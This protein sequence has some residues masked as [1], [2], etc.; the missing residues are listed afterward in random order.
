MTNLRSILGFI[1]ILT[2]LAMPHY[3]V[4]GKHQRNYNVGIEIISD[5]RGHLD[6]IRGPSR[7]LKQNNKFLIVK[8]DEPYRIRVTNYGN[9]RV[10]VV[11]AVDG[12]NVLSGR[13]TDLKFHERMAVL[14]PNQIQEFEGVQQGRHHRKGFYFNTKE[15]FYGD[16]RGGPAGLGVIALAV[17][18]EKQQRSNRYRS[19]QWRDNRRPDRA[20]GANVYFTPRKKAMMKKFITYDSRSS[21]C[22][23][24][25]IQCKPKHRKNHN[26]NNGYV[27]APSWHF[28]V[29]F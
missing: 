18:D 1:A 26:R 3:S 14:E 6:L 8:H 21:F 12:V 13:P 24:G 7:G 9:S 25:I 2:L 19:G 28:E 23:M 22:Q 5:W 29:R 27:S 17:F 11:I 10:A 20:Q 4:A 16:N 15:R